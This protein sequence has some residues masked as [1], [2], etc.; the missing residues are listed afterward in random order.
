MTFKYKTIVP[1]GRSFDEYIRMFNLSP[2]D[3]KKKIIG[4]GDGPACFNA[5]MYKLGHKVTSC[6][7]LYQLSGDHI[8]KQIDDTFE[9]VLEQTQK[10]KDRF[11]WNTIKSVKELG[12]IRMNAMN[13]FLED[14]ESGKT[15]KRYVNISLPKLDFPSLSFDLALC[16]HFLFLY[17]DNLSLSFH[18][19][20][21]KE[22]LRV[23]GEAR[24]FPILDYNANRS[25]YVDPL[26][27]LLTNAGH[28]AV[29]EKVPYEFQ[30]EGNQMMRVWKL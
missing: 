10:N 20:S 9:N 29:I 12:K 7:P 23:A 14:Y 8:K 11:M 22:M 18:H 17:T 26:I 27:D 4:C 1:W 5:E 19:K 24:I 3:L 16:S 6:D 25:T 28:R 2:K 15:Q 21:I 13:T 30:K